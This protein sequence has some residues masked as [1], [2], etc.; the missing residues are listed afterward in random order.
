MNKKG[1]KIIE[2][3]FE[4]S[5]YF[6]SVIIELILLRQTKSLPTYMGGVEG[7]SIYNLYEGYPMYQLP[8]GMR[9]F[10]FASLGIHI[11][12]FGQLLIST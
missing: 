2:N 9:T 7:S 11:L 3:A 4:S 10:F 5:I 12:R 8:Y 6:L 1:H